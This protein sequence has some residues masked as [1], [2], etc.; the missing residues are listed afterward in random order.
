MVH[1][2]NFLRCGE[3]MIYEQQHETRFETRQVSGGG[4]R[5]IAHCQHLRYLVSAISLPQ[6]V[7]R[8]ASCFRLVL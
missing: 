8:L 4:C 2:W 1:Q 5:P 6:P 3:T 7:C